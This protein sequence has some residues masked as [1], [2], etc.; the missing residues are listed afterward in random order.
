MV[1]TVTFETRYYHIPVSTLAKF[2]LVTHKLRVLTNSGIVLATNHTKLSN[3]RCHSTIADL[4]PFY[5][6]G[7]TT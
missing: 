1:V 4:Q 6:D 7:Q 5:M 2:T 3:C